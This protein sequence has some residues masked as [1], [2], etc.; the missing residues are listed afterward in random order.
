MARRTKKLDMVFVLDATNS[1]DSVFQAMRDQAMDTAF[2]IHTFSRDVDDQ[3]GIVIYRDPIDNPDDPEDKNEYFQL[4]SDRETLQE[5]LDA[6]VPHGGRDDPEDWVGAFTLALTKMHWRDGKKCLFWIT[7]ANAHGS[8]FSLERADR[9]ED[10]A[11]LLPPLVER[12]AREHIYFVAI[13]V[14]K[15]TDPGCEKTL[16]VL[17][18]IYQSVPNAPQ[19]TVQDFVVDWN[20]DEWEGDDWPPS[21]MDAFKD[22]IA[23]TLR[24]AAGGLPF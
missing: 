3:Y 23:A 10:Q 19:F 21:V 11:A 5:Y 8:R 9:H 15:G 16:N 7:D 17:R 2:S 6:V 20:R 14:R 13:N 1:T 4:T 12:A 18:Q 24:R 22:T